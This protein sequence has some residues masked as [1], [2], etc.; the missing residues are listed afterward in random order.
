M[1]DRFGYTCDIETHTNWP[2]WG[3]GLGITA[4]GIALLWLGNHREHEILHPERVQLAPIVGGG[5]FGV[6]GHVRLG[7]VR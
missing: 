3:A 2:I 1:V 6:A 5:R 7:G 4:G